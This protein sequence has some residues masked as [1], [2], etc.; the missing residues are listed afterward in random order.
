MLIIV[1]PNEFLVVKTRYFCHLHTPNGDYKIVILFTAVENLHDD[2][3]ECFFFESMKF[4]AC[5]V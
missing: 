4:F 1:R 5:L 2:R 3:V